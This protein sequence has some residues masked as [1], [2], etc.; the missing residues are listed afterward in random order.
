MPPAP[1]TVT[2]RDSKTPRD[3]AATSS[4]RPISE[5]DGGGGSR[6]TAE[7][8]VKVDTTSRLTGPQEQLPR[9]RAVRMRQI[10]ETAVARLAIQGPAGHLRRCAK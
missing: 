4:A 5:V 8:N 3:T 10:D 9:Q 2:K 7:L 1:T 6:R